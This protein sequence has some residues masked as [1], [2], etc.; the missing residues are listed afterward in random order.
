MFDV[1]DTKVFT[2]VEEENVFTRIITYGRKIGVV[3]VVEK[4]GV[5][6]SYLMSRGKKVEGVYKRLLYPMCK[7]RDLIE[8]LK[9]LLG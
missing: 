8:L 2:Y 7:L 6:Y 3:S 4:G 9:D 5:K 1:L